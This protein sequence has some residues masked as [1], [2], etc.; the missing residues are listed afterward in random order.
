MRFGQDMTQTEIGRTVGLSQMQVSRVIRVAVD[1][2]R[3]AAG[4]PAE[5]PR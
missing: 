3:V 4:P 2:L 5:G 1:R